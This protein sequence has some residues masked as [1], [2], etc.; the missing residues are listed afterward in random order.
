MCVYPS[1]CVLWC[2]S[3]VC[4]VCVQVCGRLENGS[5]QRDTW[6]RQTMSSLLPVTLHKL[7]TIVSFVYLSFLCVCYVVVKIQ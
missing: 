7:R 6:C 2:V 4:D 3:K 1:M 5:C